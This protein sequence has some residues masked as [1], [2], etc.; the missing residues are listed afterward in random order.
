MR[1]PAAVTTALF[2][3]FVAAAVPAQSSARPDPEK[4]TDLERVKYGDPQALFTVYFDHASTVLTPTAK[5]L[6]DRAA[7][8]LRD[9]PLQICGHTSGA[10][11]K[12]A[13]QHLSEQRAQVVRK[14]LIARG[15]AAE[16]LSTVGYGLT[17]P[18]DSNT[19][20]ERRQHNRRVVLKPGPPQ[21]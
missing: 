18:A 5:G 13:D 19:T 16:R 9:G 2:A 15:V 20:E 1:K 4:Q 11:D 8:S 17:Q 7:Q 6:L 12:V 3:L 10:G 14:Y 21:G